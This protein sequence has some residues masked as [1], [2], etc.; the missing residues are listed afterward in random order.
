MRKTGNLFELAERQ[1]IK[2]H[3]NYTMLDVIDY[4]IMIRKHLDLQDERIEKGQFKKKL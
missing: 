4:A 1:L 2:E 3:K